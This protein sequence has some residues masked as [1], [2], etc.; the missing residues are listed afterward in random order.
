LLA[1]FGVLCTVAVVAI[2]LSNQA[3]SDR[4]AESASEA[5]G[6]IVAKGS[7]ADPSDFERVQV[8]Y[9]TN[10][11]RTHRA[12]A[13]VFDNAEYHVGDPVGVLFHPDDP[14]R[15]QLAGDPY[16]AWTPIIASSVPFLVAGVLVVLGLRWLW[17]LRRIA[18]SAGATFAM[19]AE[20]RPARWFGISSPRLMLYLQ[21]A[22]PGT[23][24][25][26]SAPL[27]PGQEVPDGSVDV[28]VRGE[29]AHRGAIVIRADDRTL[30][31][32]ARARLEAGGRSTNLSSDWL[33][34]QGP[35]PGV[36][37]N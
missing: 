35:G 30:W 27:V 32:R 26:I 23:W 24:P 19:R 3:D 10:E 36:A 29:I 17:R 16:D 22:E 1:A 34:R 8:E 33:D 21:D 13:A 14:S 18:R 2:T 11:G 15:I 7:E 9:T 20:A 5:H 37:Q 4:F 25:V 6:E 12:E 28:L 31:P